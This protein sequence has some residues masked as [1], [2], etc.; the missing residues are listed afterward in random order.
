MKRKVLKDEDKPIYESDITN[1]SFVGILLEN[2]VRVIV[3]KRSENEYAGLNNRTFNIA[4]SWT[5]ISVQ[6]YVKQ[7]RNAKATYVFDSNIEA[8]KWLT[9]KEKQIK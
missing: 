5:A 1:E 7:M 3:V 6:E 2:D 9:R 8:L 4:K